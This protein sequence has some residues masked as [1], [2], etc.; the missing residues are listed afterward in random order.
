MTA[1]ADLIARRFSRDPS[2][3][4]LVPLAWPLWTHFKR[5]ATRFE[6]LIALLAAGKL[7]KPRAPR[8]SARRGGPRSVNALPTAKGWLIRILGWEAAGY[9]SQLTHLLAEPGAAELLALL[10]TASRILNPVK[11][12]LGAA[13]YVLH[14]RPARPKPVA[15][16][17]FATNL[18]FE[19]PGPFAFRNTGHTWYK[20][21]TPPWN[22][23]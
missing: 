13:E 2:L 6:R 3:L 5:A 1:L 22:G 17:V 4:A 15:K 14:Q 9:A 23:T 12:C 20:A 11:R 18:R 10:P 19:P 21:Y 16:P 8:A 7:P